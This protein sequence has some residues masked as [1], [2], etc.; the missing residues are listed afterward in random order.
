[1][2]SRCV[3][4]IVFFVIF[5]AVIASVARQASMDPFI[6]PFNDSSP[7]NTP[8]AVLGAK[9]DLVKC[10]MGT[11][12]WPNRSSYSP[13]IFIAV[14]SDPIW[15]V[16]HPRGNVTAN[17]PSSFSPAPGT[18][19]EL[20][21]LI[22]STVWSFWGVVIDGTNHATARFGVNCSLYGTGVG[23]YYGNLAGTRASG[24]SLLAGL[25][26]RQ[27]LAAGVI[28]HALV[29]ALPRSSLAL[30]AVPPATS[31]DGGANTTYT[32]CHHMGA[33]YAI[34]K[35]VPCPSNN[36]VAQIVWKALQDYGVMIGDATA[37]GLG[38]YL[39]RTMTTAADATALQPI[40]Q[41]IVDNLYYVASVGTGTP[42]P[43]S[44]VT[45]SP[46]GSPKTSSQ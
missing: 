35:T 45:N 8:V 11:T 27:A 5:E 46:S 10:S 30:P 24:F 4:L 18:D 7:W 38:I 6:R 44:T 39:E 9:V 22:G 32:G 36:T 21:W 37:T 17:A 43:S 15:T 1:M 2:Y 23:A 28:N 3:I 14:N 19:A 12:P 33:R 34:P 16:E 42:T 20:V 25:V 26:T 41:P 13:G 31:V 40:M 29:G